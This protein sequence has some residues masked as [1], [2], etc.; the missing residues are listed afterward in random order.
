GKFEVVGIA[1]LGAAYVMVRDRAINSVET[2]AG[3]K[4]AVLEWDRSQAKMVQQM[5]AQP[6]A[7]DI[8]NFA[9]KFNNGQV[10]IIAAPAVAFKP[11]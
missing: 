6:V 2:A 7:S 4:V 11:L 8:T 3:K 10:D 1:P 5:G 9:S